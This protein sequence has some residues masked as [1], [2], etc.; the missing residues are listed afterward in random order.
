M[1]DAD[2]VQ[3]TDEQ[4][5]S[6]FGE[7][8]SEMEGFFPERTHRQLKNKSRREQRSNLAKY[9]AFLRNKRQPGAPPFPVGNPLCGSRR[10]EPG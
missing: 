8:F 2:G 7:N 4:Y 5:L 6:I 3:V 9:E 10:M 1:D